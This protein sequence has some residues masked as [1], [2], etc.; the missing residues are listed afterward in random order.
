MNLALVALIMIAALFALFLLRMEIGFAMGLIGF[1]GFGLAVNFGAAW[2]L[3]AIDFYTVFSSYG[4]TVI[5]LFTLMGLIGA[6]AGVSTDL[7]R[8]ANKW[9]GHIPGGLAIGTVVAA[10][11]FKAICGSGTATCATFSAIAVPEMDKYG[12]DKRLSCGTVATVGTLGNLIPPSVGLV[13]YGL[14]TETSIGKLFIAGIIPGIIC[15]VVFG[16]TLW[17]WCRLRPNL[18]P[19]TAKASWTDRFKSV[20]AVLGVLIIFMVVVGG[21]MV[22]FFSPTESASVGALAVYLLVLVKRDIDFKRL[23]AATLDSVRIGCMI[24]TLIAGATV[25]GH[26]FAVTRIPFM[27]GEWVSGLQLPGSIIV[28]LIL[29]IYLIGGSIIEDAA[30][31]ILVTPIFFPTIIK[32][33]YDP[34]WF[35]IVV[36]T[37]MMM[38]IIMPPLA[39]C[40]FVVSGITKVPLRTVYQGIYPFL[41]GLT[42]CVLLFLYVPQIVL[43]LPNL[44]FK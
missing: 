1:I 31:F 7:Y 30:F 24:L 11:A 8:A 40:V 26:F 21:L 3:V 4:F 33:G 2:D 29:I 5:P 43:W 35:G 15:A 19:P 14:I 38:G 36:C 39:V 42:F 9:L 13:I 6:G 16:L 22:G 27:L 20:N 17:G 18:G 44:V 25:L 23:V 34:V 12:Y 37:A 10:T 32:L 41:W 28:I